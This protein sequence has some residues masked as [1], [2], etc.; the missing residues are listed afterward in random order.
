MRVGVK[1]HTMWVGV[2]QHTHSTQSLSCFSCIY[3]RFKGCGF[4]DYSNTDAVDEAIK[5]KYTS[6]TS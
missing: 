4:V 3:P 5:V 1:Q 2:K 6:N